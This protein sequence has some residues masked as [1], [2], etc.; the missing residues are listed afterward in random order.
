MQAVDKRGTYTW[1][2]SF[3]KQVAVHDG[4]PRRYSHD[5]I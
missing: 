5:Y 2:T 3:F 4:T 1:T